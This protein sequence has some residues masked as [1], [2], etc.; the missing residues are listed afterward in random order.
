MWIVEIGS[1]SPSSPAI[2]HA[3]DA[4]N[5]GSQ[6][7]ASPSSGAGAAGN[8]VKFTVPTVANGKVYVPSQGQLTVFGLL[9]Q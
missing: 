8:A 6:L 7:Y 2:L 4:T 1:Y 3:F 9:P 5:L